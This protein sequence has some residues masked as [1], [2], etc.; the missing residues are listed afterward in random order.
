MCYVYEFLSVQLWPFVALMLALVAIASAIAIP[1][2]AVIMVLEC[3]VLDRTLTRRVVLA[4]DFLYIV[5]LSLFCFWPIAFDMFVIP[6]STPFMILAI[7]GILVFPVP[8]VWVILHDASLVRTRLSSAIVSFCLIVL[9]AVLYLGTL[10]DFS[11]IVDIYPRQSSTLRYSDFTSTVFELFTM[12]AAL[13]TLMWMMKYLFLLIW[14]KDQKLLL[15]MAVRQTVHIGDDFEVPSSVEL[16]SLPRSTSSSERSGDEIV[17]SM[18]SPSL[19][20]R[21]LDN[22]VLEGVQPF[23]LTESSDDLDDD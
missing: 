2:V 14:Y 16:Y 23:S 7:P 6:K 19:S 12:P 4:F 22:S 17:A 10:L 13:Q 15:A 3:T 1:F 8:F 5:G 18:A 21:S 20:Q 11:A 9:L